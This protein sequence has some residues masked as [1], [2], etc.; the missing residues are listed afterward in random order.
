MPGLE[1][2]LTDRYRRML[3][4]EGTAAQAIE[5]RSITLWSGE[6]LDRAGTVVT[7]Q[8]RGAGI[9]SLCNV[10]LLS[11]GQVLGSLNLGSLRRNAFRPKTWNISS[12]WR[13]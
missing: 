4:A 13:T 6:D 2:L 3:T 7:K 12:R 8:M 10:P 5:T 11:G 1:S 9:H